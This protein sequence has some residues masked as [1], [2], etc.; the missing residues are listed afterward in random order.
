MNAYNCEIV[1][2]YILDWNASELLLFP[3]SDIKCQNEDE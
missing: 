1:F 3:S 2:S